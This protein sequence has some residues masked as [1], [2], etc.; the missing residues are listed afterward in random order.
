[1]RSF[2]II[3]AACL[4]LTFGAVAQNSALPG[5]RTKLGGT[6]PQQR[7]SREVLHNLLMNP[8]YSVFDDLAYRV[9]GSTVTL[10]G[11][12]TDPATKSD[13]VASVKHI[14]GVD[15]V[16]DRIKVLPPSSMDDQIRRAEYRA[17][18]G[19]D[20]LSRYSMGAVPPIHIIVD[21]GRVTLTGYVDNESDKNMA[22]IRANGV[23]GVFS[24][25]N[26]LQVANMTAK[27]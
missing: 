16:D 8:Y 6:D 11:A 2:L 23:P 4:A 7:L 27:K 24:V 13:A 15:K 18:F 17:I 26:N 1:M 22:G 25:T 12:V 9:D 10:M 20:G 14:E 19:Y 5:S 21:S 3:A